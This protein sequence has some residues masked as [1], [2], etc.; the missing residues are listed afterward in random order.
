MRHVGHPVRPV[1]IEPLE[2]ILARTHNHQVRTDVELVVSGSA[3]HPSA[4]IHI[5]DA[6]AIDVR[7]TPG[8]AALNPAE[9]DAVERRRLIVW[10][11][12]I[13]RETGPLIRTLTKNAIFASGRP[14]RREL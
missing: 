14:P 2:L 12:R 11:S 7:R 3:V 5:R 6:D 13:A 1:P 8:A 4:G 10:K 9:E